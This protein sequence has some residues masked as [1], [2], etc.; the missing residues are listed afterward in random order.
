MDMEIKLKMLKNTSFGKQFPKTHVQSQIINTMDNIQGNQIGLNQ[1]QK[2][3][4]QML[5]KQQS[6]VDEIDG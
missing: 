3:Q 6:Q 1:G 2:I 4:S 5:S